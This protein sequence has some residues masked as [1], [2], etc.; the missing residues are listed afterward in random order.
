MK[1]SVATLCTVAV[2]VV[3]APFANEVFAASATAITTDYLN[4]RQGA[5]T[6]TKIILTLAK[7]TTVTV[8]DNSNSQWTKIRTTNGNV[9]Y[10]SKQYL[11][12]FGGQSPSKPTTSSVTAKTT[13][14]L[15]MRSSPSLSGGIV[16]IL[17]QG[18]SLTVLDNSNSQWAKVKTPD[19]KQGW[20]ARQYL[21]ISSSGG[22][23][24][25]P[26]SVPRN[27]PKQPDP[28]PADAL[29]SLKSDTPYNFNMKQG[30]YYTYKFTGVS[31]VSYRFVCGTGSVARVACVTKIGGSYY[32]KIY[33]AGVGQSGVYASVG[34]TSQHVGVV[35]VVGTAS[36]TATMTDYVNLREGAGMNCRVIM[37]M[38]EGS[39]ATVLDNSKPDWVRVQTSDGTQ[40]WC[41]RQ[42]VKISGGNP[43]PTPTPTPKKGNTNTV[44]GAVVTA[45]LL[46]LRSGAGTS[47]S[48][49]GNLSEGTSLKVLDTSTSGWVKV[50]TPSGQT[51]YVSTDYVKL[52]YNGETGPHTNG[53]SDAISA[54]SATIPQG[55]TLWL[56][57]SSGSW[58]S[59]NPA[60]ATVSNGYVAAVAPG[61]AQ[62]TASSGSAKASCTVT[63]TAAEPVRATY[64]SP[65]IAA[66]GR[67][68]NVYG[69][70][71]FVA[72]RCTLQRKYGWQRTDAERLSVKKRDS[73]RRNNK[74]LDRFHFVPVCGYL[75]LFGY[76][77]NPRLIQFRRNFFRRDDRNTGQWVGVDS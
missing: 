65:N 72:R 54:T 51:G 62:I 43:T 34:S 41:S 76:F 13:D 5:G 37:T 17:S 42:Y 47:Y 74:G 40:G 25:S 3:S 55:K 8:L 73:Q 77:L 61:T 75:L 16:T 11:N 27:P 28:A 66:S 64:A 9:G 44:T 29:S 10:C 12:F 38:S 45:S 35:T 2:L 4:L 1:T 49:L 39:T 36:M 15:N 52:L 24:S 31:N 60:V 71:R 53:G 70:N 20:C 26:A 18:T 63:V 56:T 58:A 30:A 21:S 67:H 59:S 6:N 50:Q 7:N 33:A 57:A 48:I 32:C 23:S 22:H 14:A 46:R 69:G 68:G 19:G